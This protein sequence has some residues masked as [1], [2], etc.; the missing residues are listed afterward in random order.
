[1]VSRYWNRLSVTIY[2]YFSMVRLMYGEQI[3][4]TLTVLY[5]LEG[6]LHREV[7]P[8]L[9]QRS[10]GRKGVLPVTEISSR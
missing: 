10:G 6:T 8:L 3:S 5:N 2:F 4:N 9:L 7:R 1:M